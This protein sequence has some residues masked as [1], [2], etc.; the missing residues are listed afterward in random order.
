MFGVSKQQQKKESNTEPQ[1][2]LHLDQ[3]YVQANKRSDCQLA[4]FETWY[5]LLSGIVCLLVSL[6]PINMNE[7][8][9]QSVDVG[10]DRDRDDNERAGTR[11]HICTSLSRSPDLV[12]C[13]AIGVHE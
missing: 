4:C 2:I 7:L 1:K 3:C 6:Y 13:C 12:Q 10:A 5:M 8:M 9:V 11:S